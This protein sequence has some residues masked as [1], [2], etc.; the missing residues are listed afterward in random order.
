MR[1]PYTGAFTALSAFGLALDMSAQGPA[2][3]WESFFDGSLPGVDQANA[4]LVAGDN[5]VYVTGQ[6][7]NLAPQGT[8]TTLHY[9]SSG[10]QIF[11]D[12]VYGAAQET[13]NKGVA[14]AS[15]NI[16]HVYVCGAI[17]NN[18]GDLALIKY[19]S[20][21]RVWRENYEQYPNAE[22]E[23]QATGVAVDAEGRV[24]L[25]GYI[26]STS[27]MGYDHFLIATDSAGSVLWADDPALSSADEFAFDVA[28]SASGQPLL[29]GDWWNVDGSSGID[30]STLRYTVNGTHLWDRSFEGV[31][32]DDH[33][34][35]LLATADDGAVLCGHAMG[36]SDQ[37]M[38][39]V[40]FDAVG[41]QEWAVQYPGSGNADDEAVE[42]VELSDGRIA[43]VGRSR[44]LVDGS[45]RHA[46][47]V[48]V[49]DAGVVVWNA[50]YTGENELGAWPTGIA[51]DGLDNI[52]VSGY[53]VGAGGDYTDGVVLSYDA[54]GTLAWSIGYDGPAGFDDRFN[55]IALNSMGDVLVCGST[56]TSA[57]ATRYVTVQY[58]NAVGV[59]EAGRRPEAL[60]VR[61]GDRANCFVINGLSPGEGLRALDALGNELPLTGHRSG[62]RYDAQLPVSAGCYLL[63]ATET[64][65]IAR[66]VV[67]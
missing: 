66:V 61:Q 21:G 28:I 6:S 60:D 53:A 38:T 20:S 25:A 36:D 43:V 62:M 14:L 55:D 1:R 33:L 52:H 2:L 35:S 10:Q 32:S 59:D 15:D 7:T 12:H 16:G 19:R 17:S 18:G 48:L 64:W 31:G 56:G 63:Q 58:G 41:S 5:S 50:Q 40:K 11:V 22:V 24:Y 8:I 44:E 29:A 30:M 3:A 13:V 51:T 54:D 23:D 4:L 26:T 67:R 34:R 9:G 49:I 37:D 42:A 57:T 65:R 45:L 46:I 47:I 27:G 39:V